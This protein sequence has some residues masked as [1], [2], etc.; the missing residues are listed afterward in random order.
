MQ[1]LEQLDSPDPANDTYREAL[2]E[3]ATFVVGNVAVDRHLPDVLATGEMSPRDVERRLGALARGEWLVR[4]G[5]GFGDAPTRPLLGESLPAPPGHPASDSPLRGRDQRTFEDAVDDVIERTTDEAGI[6]L[7]EP[8]TVEHDF[9]RTVGADGPDVPRV[10]TLLPYTKRLP[11]CVTYDEPSNAL[12][13]GSCETRYNS[14][15]QGMIQAINC[16]HSLAAVDEDDIPICDV[17]LKLAPEE[18]AESEYTPTQLCFLQ[19]IYNAQQNRYDRPEFDIVRDSM[20]R[21]QEYTGIDNEAIE[22]LID[23]GLLRKDTDR[24]HRLYSVRPDG[25]EV[26]QE[27]H[28]HGVAFGHG[29][30]DLDES[31]EHVMGVELVVRWLTREYANDPDSDVVTVRPYYD[32]RE[33]SI[34]A[35]AFFG[36]DE[37]VSD[38]DDD[39][40]RHRLD[41][42]GLDAAG[43]TVVTVEVERINH[44]T[45]QAVPEDYDKMA[46]CDPDEAIWLAMSSSDAHEIVQALHDPLEGEPRIT[47]TYSESTPTSSFRIDQPGFTDC[48]TLT[49]LRNEL[50]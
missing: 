25:R 32:M 5:A 43:E 42:V 22:Q 38:A 8:A 14:N 4:P 48:Y 41:V 49:Q 31:G 45:R 11:D 3:T 50:L 9:E 47:K 40:E 7:G 34:D 37:D 1:F 36:G 33:G 13:C 24:P 18:V 44:D 35:A 28:R 30:G 26:I 16:C 23:D 21:I 27:S 2:N 20:V 17:N 29:E 39:F 19:A 46:A 12:R 15:S 6:E 10:D